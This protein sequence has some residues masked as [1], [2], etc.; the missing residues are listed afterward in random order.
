MNHIPYSRIF[1]GFTLGLFLLGCTPSNKKEKANSQILWYKKEATVWEEALPIGNGRLG[2]MVFGH[3]Q[4]EQIQLNDD[5]LWPN[6]LGWDHPSGTPEDL[7]IIRA[8]LQKGEIQTVDSLLVEKFSRKT[9]VRSHQ[10]LGD[11]FIHFD[12]DQISEYRRSLN[13]N[14]AI[15]LVSYK[16]EGYPVEQTAFLSAKDHILVVR[17][18]SAHP[19]GL[20]GT[21]RLSRP[22]DEGVATSIT[23]TE[24][25]WLIMEGEVTQRKGTFDSKPMPILE[26]VKFQTLIEPHYNGGTL[27][28]KSDELEL[29]GIN[30]IELRLVSNSSYYDPAYKSKNIETLEAAAAHSYEALKARHIEDH[31]KL[32]NR[33]SLRLE[34]PSNLDSVPTNKRL[35]SVKKG[36]VDLGLQETL[37]HYGRYLLIASSREGTL[38]A[39]LQGLWNPHI[40]APW[41][42]DYH[43][44]INLQMN[45]WLANLTQLD[46]LNGPLF[47]F[48]DKLIESGK[49]TAQK[50]F[51]M[52]GSFLPHATDLWAPTWL[53]APT[54]YWGAS[55]GAGGWM[56]Q[57]Y[58]QHYQFTQD[59]SFLEQRA[60]PALEAVAEFYS[61]WL[62]RDKRD[63]S[64]IA[65]PST[66]PEN[67]YLNK[68]G[69]PVSSCLGSAMDQQVITE[70][71]TNFLKAAKLLNQANPLTEKIK[72]QLKQIRTGFQIGA[73]GRI[74]EWDREYKE[75]EPGHRHMSHLYGFHPGDQVTLSQTPELFEAVRK[76]LD[77]RLANGG[78][79]T[80]WSRAWLINCA[81]R[82]LDGHMAQEH[83]QLLFEK[84]I[85]SN[86]FDAHPPFQIDGN[87]G[88]TAGIAEL[89]VQSHEPGIL[90]LLPA[91]P[92][93]W[94]KGFVKGLKARGN[95]EVNM[96]WEASELKT[97]QLQS[98]YDIQTQIR[99]KEKQITVN[100]KAG[101][102]YQLT[103]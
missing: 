95:I 43:L 72:N 48:T 64:L 26:G 75:Y 59:Q 12:H 20:N 101:I 98:K 42:A 15:S 40:N 38:P 57:H 90:R 6:D 80:G 69:E 73:D 47:D 23:K 67:R 63:G 34:N 8:L 100:L 61:D 103:I 44:N 4:T 97:L 102:P 36:G 87:F 89:L 30:E 65:A 50:N 35:E 53:R 77:Y 45:Y 11:L 14:E 86:L 66:S 51:G 93:N 58:W 84:S 24:K 28:A 33:V 82:L 27:I 88:Y 74:Q 13:L 1:F 5:S 46:E 9:V 49:T 68:Q 99:Y 81:A 22:K 76:T 60:Y 62:I 17:I 39:N 78:A 32:F 70:V 7:S 92:P 85:F 10:T 52:R 71:F 18:K 55:F 31:Q 41:N 94:E 54:A 29:N 21:I 3:P 79:G 96:E 2:A 91:L 16:T 83:I 37:F 19:L 25:E 56:V